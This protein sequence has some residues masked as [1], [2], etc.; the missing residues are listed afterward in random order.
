MQAVHEL[1]AEKRL[2]WWRRNCVHCLWEGAG[3]M[4][5][6]RL[7]VIPSSYLFNRYLPLVSFPFL[8][9]I[10]ELSHQIF[11]K[12]HPDNDKTVRSLD[13]WYHRGEQY[14]FFSV[15][16]IA[17]L[18]TALAGH[19]SGLPPCFGHLGESWRSH[20]W[21]FLAG[22]ETLRFGL[23]LSYSINP[24]VTAELTHLAVSAFRQ[25]QIM[26]RPVGGCDRRQTLSDGSQV[27]CWS[28]LGQSGR[29][30][31]RTPALK[32]EGPSLSKVT[33]Q[34]LCTNYSFQFH[35][36]LAA[37]SLHFIL[38]FHSFYF[39]FSLPQY[40]SLDIFQSFPLDIS[41]PRVLLHMMHWPPPLIFWAKHP[42][43]T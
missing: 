9:E 8:L 34:F 29:E 32:S 43:L 28:E 3:A 14:L 35:Q 36:D 7:K 19:S 15:L 33:K 5:S 38:C 20:F 1:H 42:S 13:E 6:R 23:Q 4:C 18:P 16:N 12:L 39:H 11:V 26:H 27:L 41:S 40:T 22:A 25:A 17:T 10:A 2:F 30:A 21:A 37:F 24:G 31:S